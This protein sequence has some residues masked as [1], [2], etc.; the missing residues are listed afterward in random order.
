[1]KHSDHNI[2]SAGIATVAR[3]I[4]DGQYGISREMVIIDHPR[5]GRLLLA[6]EYGGDLELRGGTYRWGSAYRLHHDD[7]F[8]VLEADWN[9]S[10]SILEAVQYMVDESRPWLDW[11]SYMVARLAGV[12]R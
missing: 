6:Q 5:H 3:R 10:T 7:T 12:A 2:P 1:M 4:T 9:E 11:P 8:E